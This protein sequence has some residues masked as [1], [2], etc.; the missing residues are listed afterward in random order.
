MAKLLQVGIIGANP[1]G[2]WAR[3]SHIPALQALPGLELAAVAGKTQ[4]SADAAARG[5]AISK[6]YGDAADLFRDPGIDLVTIAV[7]LP[8]HRELL[9]AAMQA[10]KHVYCEYPLGLDVQES[11]ALAR[12][13][14][15]AG[16]HAAIGL[17]ARANPAVR[18]A[19]ALLATN[20]IGRPLTARMISTTAGF[21]PNT[22]PAVA[23]TEDPANGVTV[24]T[25][26]AAHSIDLAMALL[27]GIAEFSALAT[28]Q[29]PTIRIGDGEPQQR[30]TRDHLLV[31][32]RLASGAALSVEVAGGR[33]P[34]TPFL[35][36]IVGDAGVMT[37]QGG[38]PRGFQSGRLGLLVNG[39]AQAV[40]EGELASMSDAA[41]NVAATYARFRDDI[42]RQTSTVV[43][44]GHAVRMAQFME[45]A[46]ASSDA[47]ERRKH[48]ESGHRPDRVA[49]SR[50][51]ASFQDGSG[52]STCPIPGRPSKQGAEASTPAPV[53]RSQ[54]RCQHWP[55]GSRRCPPRRRQE[56]PE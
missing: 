32:A 6:A 8:A 56:R 24:I 42:V 48:G 33:P 45:D 41:L 5:F 25:I 30:K 12:A 47:G 38:A 4:Q 37:L 52:V 31:Q 9:L 18:R 55:R 54:Q 1:D 15:A 35:F 49:A 3:E 28:T 21:G 36:E 19:Q 34:E 26:Q 14:E 10:G 16:V 27:G 39:E 44:F 29:F 53:P 11:R 2:G 7:T 50:G 40:D 17:Q 43:G 22:D 51:A 46:V 13:A 20:A 23:Y